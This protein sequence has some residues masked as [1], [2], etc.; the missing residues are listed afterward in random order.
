MQS[1]LL[2]PLP[3]HQS[4]RCGAKT[5]SGQSCCSPAMPNGRCRMHGGASTGAPEGNRSALKHGRCT[6]EAL[7]ER[8]EMAALIRAMKA[9][10]DDVV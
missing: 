5:R 4:P 2:S 9:S 10:I 8:R 6:A 1:A 3:M 7:T